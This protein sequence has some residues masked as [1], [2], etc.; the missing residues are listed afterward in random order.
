M[1]HRRPVALTDLAEQL[2]I[3]AR[4]LR[5]QYRA[6]RLPAYTLRDVPKTPLFVDAE[7]ADQVRAW[8]AAN[9]KKH[10]PT[11][12]LEQATTEEEPDGP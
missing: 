12:P 7:V 10:W 8:H 4:A 3:S 11:F 2:G 6:G 1:T 9:P 5:L